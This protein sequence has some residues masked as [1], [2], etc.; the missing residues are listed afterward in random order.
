[1]GNLRLRAAAPAKAGTLMDDIQK[2]N[3]TADGRNTFNFVGAKTFYLEN[4]RWVDAQYDGKAKTNVLKLYSPEY[5]AFVAANAG[6]GQF[7]AQGDRVVVCWKDQ[8]YETMPPN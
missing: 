5:Y 2:Q 7:L 1:M 3:Q 8:V 6:A 4:D